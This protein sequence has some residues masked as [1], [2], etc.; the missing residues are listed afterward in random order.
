MIQWDVSGEIINK[1]PTE[2]FYEVKITPDGKYIAAV[3]H[4]DYLYVY[5]FADWDNCRR[6]KLD[7]FGRSLQT[8]LDSRH[9]IV[10]LSIPNKDRDPGH[11]VSIKTPT[12]DLIDLAT[13]QVEKRYVGH[14]HQDFVVRATFGGAHEHFVVSGSE[15]EFP[16]LSLCTKT[17]P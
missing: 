3:N 15:G 10:N 2:R 17:N 7:G 4:T 6:Y 13:G 11:I 16:I 14:A 5:D 12:V 9:V 8:S 1:A